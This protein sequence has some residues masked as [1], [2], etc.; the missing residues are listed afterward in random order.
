MI[1]LNIQLFGGSPGSPGDTTNV[2]NLVTAAPGQSIIIGKQTTDG[3]S[4]AGKYLASDM[5]DQLYGKANN[6]VRNNSEAY[7][8]GLGLSLNKNGKKIN[9]ISDTYKNTFHLIKAEGDDGKEMYYVMHIDED[10]D[11]RISE[12][13]HSSQ[14]LNQINSD[15]VKG[16]IIADPNGYYKNAEVING[17]IDWQGK[18]KLLGTDAEGNKVFN[19]GKG[20]VITSTGGI[21]TSYTDNN[22]TL[23][24]SNV[25]A[26]GTSSWTDDSGND[27]IIPVVT[28]NETPLDIA[29]KQYHQYYNDLYSRKEGTL[30]K[31][32]LDNNISLFEKEAENTGILAESSLQNQAMAQAQGIRQVTDAIRSE[33]MAQLRAGMSES[34]LADRE[35]QML[36]G[37]VNN[38]SNQAQAASQERLAAGLGA[39]TAREQAF[40]QYIDQTTALGQNATANY[41]SEVGDLYYKAYQYQRDQQALGRNVT[42]DEAIKLMSGQQGKQ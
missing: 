25:G 10:G 8:Q 6:S 9:D 29:Y 23:I 35:L 42:M 31:E 13:G 15:Y 26:D 3:T 22:G 33:R 37:S 2:S 27:V 24:T 40:N 16:S 7:L 14:I 11:V 18:S 36:M 21:V 20:N 39:N 41:A 19:D 32:I 4:N 34:Q 38:F 30:G 28:A 1:K 5:W 17:S 12:P